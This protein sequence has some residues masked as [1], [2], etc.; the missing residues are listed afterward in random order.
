MRIRVSIHAPVWGATFVLVPSASTVGEFQ[1][2]RPCGARRRRACA[3]ACKSAVSI[4]APVWG[5]TAGRGQRRPARAVSIHAPVWGATAARS[6]EARCPA[7]F[8]STRPCGARQ[9]LPALL[10]TSQSFQSTRPCG[11]RPGQRFGDRQSRRV[12]IHAPVWGA[13]GGVVGL[14]VALHRFNPRARVGR[15]PTLVISPAPLIEF[16]STR[17]CGARP[18]C[19]AARARRCRFNPRARVGRDAALAWG[20]LNR[21]MFQ[22]TRPCG[23]RRGGNDF[24]GVVNCV[25]IHAPVWG[26]T[27]RCRSPATQE[28]VS[29]HAPVWGAT[30]CGGHKSAPL[31]FQSTRPCG[32]RLVQ[33]TGLRDRALVSIHAPVWGATRR[34]GHAATRLRVSIHAPVWGATKRAAGDAWIEGRFNPRARVGRDVQA[35]DRVSGSTRVSIHAPVWGATA[36]GWLWPAVRA[37][38]NP[39][40]RVGR[41]RAPRPS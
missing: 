12:S 33:D 8:Q 21:A 41:D 31:Q 39:R 27:S 1:S 23:A 6:W 37:G 32:A 13:T 10:L 14:R 30:I 15:D 17:P 16:Q 25:S 38:F 35:I 11:A 19:A 9:P 4:H 36:D 22:S 20:K 7:P 28:G 5:A 18:R 40:A 2:T 24:V 34:V 3:R 29:I 26:A